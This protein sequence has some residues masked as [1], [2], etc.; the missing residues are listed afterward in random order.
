[1]NGNEWLTPSALI[2]VIAALGV[3]WAA[4]RW[5]SRVDTDLGFLR[6]SVKTILQHLG[7]AT[8]ISDSP[9]IL[10]DL[11]EQ[12]ARELGAEKWAAEIAPSLLPQIKGNRAFEVDEFAESYV[13]E[14]LGDEWQDRV[15]ASAYEHG[16]K[17]ANILNVLRVVLRVELLRAGDFSGPEDRPDSAG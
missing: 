7:L 6:G 8:V 9:M 15:A 11:G 13:K 5:T 17:R 2:A 4:A 16:L 12:I 10:T 1:M 14:K 3:L